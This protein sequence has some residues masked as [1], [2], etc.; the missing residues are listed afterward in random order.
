RG[1]RPSRKNGHPREVI[2]KM[3]GPQHNAMMRT[4]SNQSVI[5][6]RAFL[7]AVAGACTAPWLTPA[8]EAQT[9]YAD[10]F[11]IDGGLVVVP[12]KGKM[13]V[14]SDFHARWGQFREWMEKTDLVARLKGDADAYGLIL[15]DA[16]DFKQGD[17]EADADGDA[18]II[19]RI[20]EL[21]GTLG[22]AGKRLIYILGNHDYEATKY[23]EVMKARM[24]AGRTRMQA[25]EEMYA[26]GINVLQY[27]FLAR[28]TEEQQQYLL[29]VPVA[30]LCKNGVFAVHAGPAQNLKGIGDIVQRRPE[31]VE[32]LVWGRP[33]MESTK[34]LTAGATTLPADA[35]NG[36]Y[37]EADVAPFLKLMENSGLMISGHNPHGLFPKTMMHDGLAEYGQHQV[38]LATSMGALADGRRH[39]VI[40]LGRRYGS[41]KDLVMGREIQ[42][43]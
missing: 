19:D 41:V 32:R 18:K 25:L 24:Q 9:G 5:S 29:K 21:Q 4:G 1:L 2:V 31:V 39:L 36:L 6:R 22:E 11:Q 37:A 16:V 40:D 43:L 17:R 34:E 42:K 8:L 27:N 3:A 7:G 12:A 38:I 28:I 13:Y 20:R 35:W 14:A 10:R 33:T 15:G 30:V 26:A 23:Y